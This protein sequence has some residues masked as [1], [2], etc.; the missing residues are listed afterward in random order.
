MKHAGST[1]QDRAAGYPSFGGFGVPARDGLAYPGWVPGAT[2]RFF[3]AGTGLKLPAG[4]DLLVQVHYAP[5][6]TR[7]SDQSSV[8]L[9]FAE[10]PVE[11]YVKTRVMLPSD[12]VGEDGEHFTLTPLE[13]AI[14]GALIGAGVQEFLGETITSSE[15]RSLARNATLD[16][17]FGDQVG[18]TVAGFLAF[19]IPANTS[20]NFRGVW[21]IKEDVSLL[22]VWPHMHYLG[23]NW[24]II[25]EKPDGSSENLIRIGD[26]NFNWQGAYTFPTYIHAPAGSKIY[27]FRSLRQYGAKL[28]Q[29]Q[30]SPEGCRLG[31]EDDRRNVFSSVWICRLPGR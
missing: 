8:N 11:R 24:E 28:L 7:A 4:A 19:D 21:N 14:G 5:W 10:E 15:I 22:N 23:K 30:F 16:T 18:G 2:P 17:V 9:F 29:S 31:G 13:G 25:L 12:L 27:A 1:P 20:Q 3:P 6:P 26:W